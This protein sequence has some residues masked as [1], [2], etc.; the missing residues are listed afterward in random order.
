MS[1][2]P[3]TLFGLVACIFLF[4]QIARAQKAPKMQWQHCYGGS[5]LENSR[6]FVIPHDH[7]MVHTSDGGYAFI[8]QTNSYDGPVTG[9]HHDTTTNPTF[10]IWL[11]KTD[12]IG[13][14]QWEK[15]Y[16]GSS[17]ESPTCLIQTSDGGF[18]M[19]GTTRSHDGDIT[20]SHPAGSNDP[21][22]YV[23]DAWI[24][25]V[26]ARGQKEWSHCYGWE[27]GDEYFNDI[28]E[29]DSGYLAVGFSTSVEDAPEG[30][31]LDSKLNQGDALVVKLNSRGEQQWK[32]LYGGTFRDEANAVLPYLGGG[33]IFAGKLGGLGPRAKAWV[34][35]IDTAGIVVWQKTGGDSKLSV[36]NNLVRTSTGYLVTGWTMPDSLHWDWK[37]TA[38]T[39]GLAYTID[40][41]GKMLA[42]KRFGGTG[43]DIINSLTQTSDG[44][45]VFAGSTTSVEIPGIH[46]PVDADTVKHNLDSTD[47]WVGSFTPDL[48]PIWQ[49]AMGGDFRD[50]FYTVLAMPNVETGTNDIMLYGAA[51]S[52]NNWDGGNGDHAGLVHGYSDAWVVKLSDLTSSVAARTMSTYNVYPNPAQRDVYLDL[53]EGAS[54][55]KV[56]FFDL[57]GSEVFPD[58]RIEGARVVANVHEL[59]GGVYEIKVSYTNGEEQLR[60]FLHAKY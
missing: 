36:A 41:A 55:A 53:Y 9:N 33:Y 31:V 26:D 3:R 39:D 15:C 58:Y 20:D 35:R 11:V 51:E 18:A 5:E 57:L 10:D 21:L 1:F 13:N 29:V 48:K 17:D 40:T 38:T 25:K 49:K 59:P 32:W 60:K 34:V 46:I 12:I 47:A 4:A 23:N 14:I 30:H 44:N 56:Q 52:G 7:M 24:I 43:N 42:L 37:D 45:F 2:T 6:Q 54:V 22:M 27:H 50:C 8:A 28:I 19:C 16:G